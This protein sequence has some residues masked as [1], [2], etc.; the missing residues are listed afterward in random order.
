MISIA[1]RQCLTFAGVATAAAA[2]PI[3]P[4]SAAELRQLTIQVGIAP[5]GVTDTVARM[6][7]EGLPTDLAEVALV[8]NRTGAGGQLVLNT[9]RSGAQDGSLLTLTPASQVTVYP[10]TYPN[11]LYDPLKDF[12]PV[13]LVGVIE[14]GLAVG[15]L[16]PAEVQT[17]DDFL[18]WCAEHPELATFGSPAAG[19][20]PHFL[21]EL[22][23]RA[24]GVELVHVPYRGTQP[25]ISD[26]IGGQIAAVSGTVG[27]FAPFVE[28]GRIRLLATSGAERSRFVSNVPTYTEQGFPDLQLV[29]WMGLFA[30]AGVA[31]ARLERISKA[32][33]EVL[34]GERARTVMASAGVEPRGSSPQVLSEWLIEDYAR[35]KPIV[36]TVGFQAL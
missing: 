17:V 3:R 1:R 27:G 20:I 2:W 16:V 6:L 26:L 15:P 11:L 34:Q 25:A 5:G 29:E 36:E 24:G 21:G 8:E 12:S 14:F 33:H 10:H 9:L 35:W 7:A 22:L 31:P 13:S 23:G 28:Q 32:V 4:L 18:K 19:S 30:P